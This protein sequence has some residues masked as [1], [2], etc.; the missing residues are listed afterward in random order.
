MKIEEKFLGCLKYYKSYYDIEINRERFLENK[1]NINRQTNAHTP[2]VNIS[3]NSNSTANSQIEKLENIF[4][5]NLLKEND[6]EGAKE[7]EKTQE[8]RAPTDADRSLIQRS[9]HNLSTKLK[10]RLFLEGNL[11]ANLSNE[12]YQL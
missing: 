4:Q 10:I 11:L 7:K 6:K 5:E 8:E 1:N 9:Q 3:V 2:I 12:G